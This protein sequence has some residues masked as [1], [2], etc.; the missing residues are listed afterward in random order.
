M[1]RSNFLRDVLL[2]LA[3]CVLL[4]W[5]RL[6]S[7]GLI[8]PDEPFYAQ[9]AREMVETN[10][11]ITPH[12]FGEPQFEKP[13]FYYW[14]AAGSFKIFGINEFAGRT[15]SAFFATVLVL[16]TY[17]FGA[18]V[19][20]PRAGFL[21]ALILATG[22][23]F[24]IMARLMLTDIALAAFLAGA[25]YSY[26]LAS[27]SE[28]KTRVR[29]IVLHFICTALAV[30]TK[31][32]LGSWIPLI[33]TLTFSFFA[34]NR[35]PLRGRGLVAG[36][37][38]YV[39]IAVPWY[40]IMLSKFGWQYAHDFFW[41]E[42]IE[43]LYRAEHRANN[44]FYYYIGVLLVGSVPWLPVLSVTITRAFRN[45][46]DNR[47]ALFLW[48]W[49]LSSLIFFTAAQS[50]L[51][52]YIFFLFVPAA[53]L[54]GRVLDDLL[55]N[56]FR[57]AAER[58]I[59]MG[60]GVLQFAAV[61]VAPTVK[62]AAPFATPAIA[63]AVVLL[64]ASVFLFARQ[65]RIWIALNAFSTAVLLVSALA[66]AGQNVEAMSSTRPLVEDILRTRIGNEPIL[67][68]RFLVRGIFFYLQEPLK[69][70]ANKPQPFFTRHPV[71]V[72]VG[73]SGLAE[74]LKTTP[75]ALCVLTKNEWGILQ[76]SRFVKNR[77]AFHYVGDKIVVRVREL[78]E[79]K[80]RAAERD[81][82]PK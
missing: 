1:A 58:W 2:L 61:L 44:H 79:K 37:L 55:G 29:W 23:E 28:G 57:T 21:A 54:S 60:A 43:R 7:L 49:L 24:T 41:H 81:E 22:V 64:I 4:F 19:F 73:R 27:E 77:E 8:D 5:W 11:W 66:L 70:F 34:R 39:L 40:A 67:S 42:N 15:P 80:D 65:L 75:T 48:S 35:S 13:I 72:I 53:L 3:V 10:D 16:M 82:S 68:G 14:L 32:P 25:L 38:L 51:P 56:G 18:R 78:P 62:V 17:A 46:R 74:F 71:P 9:T 47:P 6:G 33:A 45:F 69:I 50:K 20:N 31:G 12:I 26:W 30:L 59:A 76:D 63:V 52:S 36:I